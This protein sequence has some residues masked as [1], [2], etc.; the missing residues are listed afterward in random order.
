MIQM[1]NVQILMNHTSVPAMKGSLTNHLNRTR[2]QEEFAP[3]VRSE[4]EQ[5]FH[6]ISF[7]RTQ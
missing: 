2:N 7:F 3:N 1:P 4:S 6:I 5:P